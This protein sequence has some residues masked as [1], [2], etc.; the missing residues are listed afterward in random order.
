MSPWLACFL[1]LDIVVGTA[2]LK[3]IVSRHQNKLLQLHGG[4][5]AKI[6]PMLESVNHEKQ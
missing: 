4:V 1:L 2:V 3:I 5:E 6:G